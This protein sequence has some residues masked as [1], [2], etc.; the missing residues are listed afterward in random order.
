MRQRQRVLSLCFLLATTVRADL[1]LTEAYGCL[2]PLHSLPCSVVLIH[3]LTH[4]AMHAPWI[5]MVPL[6]CRVWPDMSP[7]PD[8]L[9]FPFTISMDES[10]N[11]IRPLISATAGTHLALPRIL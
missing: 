5:S 10:R 2:P 7:L 6:H 9:R 3:P 8:I 1:T 11:S 4:P